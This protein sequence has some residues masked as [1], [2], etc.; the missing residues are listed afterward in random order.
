MERLAAGPW[1]GEFGWE[2]MSW[3][4]YLR[5]LAKQFD[6]VI[7]C[8]QGGHDYFYRDF[9]S[10]Y[11]PYDRSGT[12]DCWWA[13]RSPEDDKVIRNLR[14]KGRLIRPYGL[15]PFTEQTFIK[16][17]DAA[18]G[19]AADILV[20]ARRPIGKRPGHAWPLDKWDVLVERLRAA[21]LSVA[22][23]GTAA[24]CPKGAE[25]RRGLP[26]AHLVDDIAASALVIGPSSGPMHLASLCGTP[27]LV[28][29]GTEHY[30]AI[31]ANNR[32]RY[33]SK[34]NPLKT[35]CHIV[36]EF[37]WVPP[38]DALF[39]RIIRYHEQIRETTN[40]CNS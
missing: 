33:E 2:L 10:E 15:I 24:D 17:G 12:K 1:V 25:D 18:Q 8:G 22:A 27:H 21:G 35:P 6:E 40:A 7:V 28:W 29:T 13:A 39:N 16:F 3:Q 31:R 32:M 5:K 14:R 19:K 38:V 23:I 34:W 4:G 20:H 11:I 26:M 37:G 30:S 9:A 36:D